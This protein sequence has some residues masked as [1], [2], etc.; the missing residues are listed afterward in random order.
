[1]ICNLLANLNL[2]IEEVKYIKEEIIAYFDDYSQ[3]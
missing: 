1:M 2:T 3:N